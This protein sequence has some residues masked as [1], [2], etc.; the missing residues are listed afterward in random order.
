MPDGDLSKHPTWMGIGKIVIP[1]V[2]GV[3]ST[4]FV[5]GSARQKVQDVVKWKEE[6]APRIERMDATGTLSFAH[7]HTQYEK[8][9]MHQLDRIK[10]LEKE[11]R[12]IETMKLKIESL[13]RAL[14]D[15]R[16]PPRDKGSQ[17]YA[18]HHDYVTDV[19]F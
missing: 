7:F 14:L 3:I 13:E 17:Y 11:A 2:I 12:Q 16:S 19:R 9:Q 4:A 15:R 5:V 6:M 10:E 18:P 8:E 1:F